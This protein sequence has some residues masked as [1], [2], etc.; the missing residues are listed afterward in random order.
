MMVGWR[1]LENRGRCIGTA[2][3]SIPFNRLTSV[4]NAVYGRDIIY[5]V[6]NSTRVGPYQKSQGHHRRI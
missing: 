5:M 6:I 1:A 3:G 2:L 4:Q